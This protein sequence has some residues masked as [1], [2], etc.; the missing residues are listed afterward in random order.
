MELL[1]FQTETPKKL[2]A[3]KD[4]AAIGGAVAPFDST[5]T[6]VSPLSRDDLATRDEQWRG[7]GER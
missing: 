2:P 7:P 3:V 4:K 5:E 6:G 1:G